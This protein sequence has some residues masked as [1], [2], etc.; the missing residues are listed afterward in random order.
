MCCEA[1]TKMGGKVQRCGDCLRPLPRRHGRPPKLVVCEV[2]HLGSHT[3]WLAARCPVIQ[4]QPRSPHPKPKFKPQ[5][6]LTTV[7]SR[8]F[9]ASVTVMDR[10]L[11]RT[12]I[13]LK[14]HKLLNNLEA[15]AASRVF[16][17]AFLRFA[18]SGSCL[19]VNGRIRTA[20]IL[21]INGQQLNA[22]CVGAV[23]FLKY[24]N[25]QTTA[26]A[27]QKSFSMGS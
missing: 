8:A 22:F 19:A 2:V 18:I 16:S 9:N 14:G 11:N 1:P 10:R 6:L 13:L 26:Y 24:L 3:S 27:R 23:Q 17:L 12:T 20:L 25:Q 15:K 4:P 21:C 5:A 7:Y